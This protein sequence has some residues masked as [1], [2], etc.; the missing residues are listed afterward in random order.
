[1]PGPQVPVVSALHR[2]IARGAVV[3][4]CTGII[5]VRPGPIE[6]GTGLGPA[7]LDQAV[8]ASELKFAGRAIAVVAGEFT[9]VVAGALAAAAVG[10]AA[11]A[12]R[13]ARRPVR[14]CFGVLRTEAVDRAFVTVVVAVVVPAL[15]WNCLLY[16]SP[17]PRDATLSRMPSSA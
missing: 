9:D 5:V 14:S 6:T 10:A 8:V 1:M 15:P 7:I 16:T 12:P 13:V 3:A 2:Q 17:S 4:R 11:L